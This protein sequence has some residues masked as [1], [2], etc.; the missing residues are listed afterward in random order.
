MI[1]TGE[2]TNIPQQQPA[3][4]GQDAASTSSGDIL[5]TLPKWQYAIP[6]ELIEDLMLTSATLK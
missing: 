2:V 5:V 4:Q 3:P 1:T 6:L